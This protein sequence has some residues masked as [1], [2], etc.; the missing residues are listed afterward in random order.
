MSVEA[1]EPETDPAKMTDE[2]IAEY[3]DDISGETK[4]ARGWPIESH[5][6]MLNRCNASLARVARHLLARKTSTPT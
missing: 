2:E 5:I 4:P 3:I 1:D 6:D